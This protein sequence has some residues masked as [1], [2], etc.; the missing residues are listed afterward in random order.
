M[1]VNLVIHDPC[2]SYGP[3]FSGQV[4]YHLFPIEYIV[5]LAFLGPRNHLILIDLFLRL[6]HLNPEN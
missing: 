3:S 1:R 4:P 6:L 2:P 5:G